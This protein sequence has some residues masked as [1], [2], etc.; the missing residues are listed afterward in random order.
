MAKRKEQVKTIV[1]LMKLP[2]DLVRRIDFA[3]AE[4]AR[5]EARSRR[6][7]RD[8]IIVPALVAWFDQ[9]DREEEEVTIV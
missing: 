5:E 6:P 3:R 4:I 7:T 9:M 1:V 8:E 2:A